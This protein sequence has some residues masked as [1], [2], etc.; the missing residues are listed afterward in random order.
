MSRASVV[1]LLASSGS[2]NSHMMED[3]EAVVCKLIDFLFSVMILTIFTFLLRY[4]A[5]RDIF[6]K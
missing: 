1:P 6:V 5:S 4:F 2:E 3:L